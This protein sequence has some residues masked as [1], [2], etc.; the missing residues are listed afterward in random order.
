M[1]YIYSL[2]IDTDIAYREKI[3]I[4]LN[5]DCNYLDICWGLEIV[6]EEEHEY[7]DFINY[8]LDLLEKKYLR[9]EQIGVF[10]EHIS[11]WMIYEYN[12]QCNIQFIPKD[13]KRLGENGVSLCVSCYEV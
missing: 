3:N 4:I 7:F 6:E 1:K 2:R 11:I 9:L 10:R 5:K 12:N 8:F 13:L